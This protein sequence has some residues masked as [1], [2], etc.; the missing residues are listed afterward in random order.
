MVIHI[1]L[2]TK[3]AILIAIQIYI[4]DCFNKKRLDKEVVGDTI[5]GIFR[6]EKLQRYWIEKK[7]PQDKPKKKIDPKKMKFY[8]KNPD[9]FN[10][11]LA[12]NKIKE[13]KE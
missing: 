2:G 6:D 9:C 8:C 13:K 1:D 10:H 11:Y 12:N 5:E 7:F 3:T 4:E